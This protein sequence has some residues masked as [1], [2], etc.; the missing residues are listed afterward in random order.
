ME[1]FS[2][3]SYF[4]IFLTFIYI[5]VVATFIV[6][7]AK[8]KY[9]QQKDNFSKTFVSIIIAARNEE[10]KIFKTIEDILGQRYPREL[11]ELIIIDDHSTD[12]TAEIVK[13]YADVKLIQLNEKQALN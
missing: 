4:S 13:G 8:I 1:I 2:A 3:I 7:L 12:R 5:F 6:G 9:H 10:D 11:F